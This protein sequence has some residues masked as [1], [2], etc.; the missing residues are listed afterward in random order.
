VEHGK[1]KIS[2]FTEDKEFILAFLGE[3]EF[4]GEM[5]LLNHVA[6]NASAI[7]Y[8]EA[9]V[10]SLQKENLFK[11]LKEPILKK[12]FISLAQRLWYSYRR[13]LN[14]SYKS[15]VTRLYDFLDLIM[16][17]KEDRRPGNAY[18][19]DISFED[20]KVMANVQD[21]NEGQLDDFIS[22]KNLIIRYGLISIDDMELFQNKL[23]GLI[24]LEKKV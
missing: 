16:A 17:S 9:R 24:A 2:H 18:R 3:G 12:I 15:P 10:L 14:L 11:E 1:V 7:A 20:L 4:F 6:R 22:D 8:S 5:A 13:V 21:M 19:F 23:Q